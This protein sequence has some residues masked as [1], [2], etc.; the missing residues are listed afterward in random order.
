MGK[1]DI[2]VRTNFSEKNQINAAIRDLF[3]KNLCHADYNV[4][5]VSKNSYFADEDDRER[6]QSMTIQQFAQYAIDWWI[7]S[8]L[9][10]GFAVVITIALFMAG[11]FQYVLSFL[12]FACQL[13]LTDL[14]HLKETSKF[15]MNPPV[16]T[17]QDFKN[18]KVTSNVQLF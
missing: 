17:T 16:R 15:R 6:P 7:W 1:I 10:K 12:F 18:D 4:N 3:F 8:W 9:M 11:F 14:E 13:P 5:S 2:H